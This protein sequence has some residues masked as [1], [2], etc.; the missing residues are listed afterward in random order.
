MFHLYHHHDMD[1]LAAL[2]AVLLQRDR[3][4]SPLVP[5][6]VIV[7]NQGVGRWLQAQL[8]ESEGIAANIAFPL[9]AGFIWTDLLRELTGG[10][11]QADDARE[12]FRDRMVWHLFRLLPEVA[13]DEPALRR[14]LAADPPDIQ[15]LQLAERLADVFDQYQVFRGDMLEAWGSGRLRTDAATEQWQS[16]VWQAL[17]QK[18]GQ[19]DRSS[20]LRQMIWQLTANGHPPRER[21]F[22]F[23]IADLPP[24]YLRLFYALGQTREVHFLL[25]NPSDGYWGDISRQRLAVG[26]SES[27]EILPAEAVVE[28]SHPLLASLGRPIRD[29]IHLL[30]SQEMTAIQEPELGSAMAYEP[31]GDGCLL[32]RIQSGIIRLDA[33]PD[34]GG[35]KDDDVSVQVHACHGPLREVQV[36][37]DQLL[38]LLGRDASL[39]PREI[40]VMMP[41]PAAYAP[42]IRSVFG[43]AQ[44][45]RHIPW[46]V[47]GQPR[48]ASH[49]IVQTFRGLLDLPLSRWTV[50]EVLTLAAVPAVMRRFGLDPAGLEMLT[51]WASEAGIRWGL[52][53]DTRAALGAG[54]Y[55]ANTWMFGLD[56]LLL[57]SVLNDEDT[58]VADVAPWSDLEGGGT[59]ALGILRVFV[60]ELQRWQ[61]TLTQARPAAQWR[62]D[63][64]ILLEQL[65]LVDEDERAEREALE[66]IHGALDLLLTADECLHGEPLSWMVLREALVAALQ[67]PGTRQPFLTGGV[68]FS[69]LETMAGVPF[70]VVCLLGMNDGAFPRQDG[71][72]EFNLILHRRALGDRLNRDDDRQA[73]LQALLAARDVFYLSY[74]GSDV[75]SG[76]TLEPATTVAEFMDFMRLYHF[77][78]KSQK[79][80]VDRIVTAQPMQ[81][82]SRRYFEAG[83]SRRVFTFAA[84]WREGADAQ[85]R[86]RETQPGLLD[87]SRAPEVSLELIE[88][89][90]LRYFFRNPPAF[91]L[92]ERLGLNLDEA[93][94]RL[95]DNEPFALDGLDAWQLRQRLL[96][97]AAGEPETALDDR[98]SRLW[99]R[100]GVLPPPPLDLAAWQPAVDAVRTLLPIRQAWHREPAATLDIQLQLPDGP[101]L[102]GRLTDLRPGGLYR[103]RPGSLSMRNTLPDWI[104]YLALAATGT[105]GALYLAGLNKEDADLRCARVS[106][107]EALEV[108]AA[109]AYWYAEGQRT[110][111]PFLPDVAELY[112]VAR[113]RELD[114]DVPPETAAIEALS[115]INARLDPGAFQRHYSLD[116]P[117]FAAV[118]T[119]GAPLGAAPGD[120][121]FCPLSEAVCGL[122]HERLQTLDPEGWA[123]V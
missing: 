98:P 96:T 88:L 47:S 87:G 40:V 45:P 77:P 3:P 80:F 34:T 55:D 51:H 35:M 121:A 79:T 82:F 118:L 67:E 26:F 119:P 63:F 50:S 1:R 53:A 120:T 103:L 44:G 105:E 97:T 111:L 30:Y 76:E 64:N 59:A 37:H 5:E 71:G 65:F 28:D 14:Y 54:R 115:A 72:R 19:G 46:S 116:D 91:F 100:R 86:P 22:C 29:F 56:R 13:R 94:T 95:E 16:K 41:D 117:Y 107:K 4:A 11:D 8:A 106:Q 74:I 23:G 43:A 15:R 38:D 9:P 104:D 39:R 60:E 114:Q 58:L 2:L 73:F 18:L 113:S 69:D 68:T 123:D 33:A 112:L 52:D 36:L 10:N 109:L 6:C 31:P 75:R 57:G 62:L 90:A 78:D 21:L 25:P 20:R 101:R 99:Q 102:S 27:D 70:R 49:P 17:R 83:N 85:A 93:D 89:D 48:W 84:D 110:P 7:P 32:H 108:L 24:D 61:K 81:P 122:L 92:R 66:A 42:A 12:F